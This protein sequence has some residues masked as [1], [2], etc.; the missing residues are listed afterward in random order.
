MKSLGQR[1]TFGRDLW[2]DL[3]DGGTGLGQRFIEPQTDGLA[4]DYTPAPGEQRDFPKRDGSNPQGA[5]PGC[6]LD[7][8]AHFS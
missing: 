4:E 7:L 8:V 5:R 2:T 6:P 3:I 1:I